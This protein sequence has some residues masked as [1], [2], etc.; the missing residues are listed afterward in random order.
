MT[1]AV[2]APLPFTAFDRCDR[3]Q[4]QAKVR[5]TLANGELL[6]CGHHGR[7]A[8]TPLVLSSLTVYDPEG[9]FNYGKQ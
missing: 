4:A 2:V 9:V 8:G 1:T 6:F 7:V 3:C 5:A